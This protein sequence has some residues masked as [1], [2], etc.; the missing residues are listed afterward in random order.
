MKPYDLKLAMRQAL[1]FPKTIVTLDFETYYNSADGYSL[2]KMSTEEY[3]RDP[4][5][6]VHGL[7]VKLG[8]RPSHWLAGEANVRKFLKQIPLHKAWCVAQNSKF[9]GLILTEHFGVRPAMWADTMAMAALLFGNNLPSAS[10][11]ALAARFLPPELAKDK[12][13]LADVDGVEFPTREQMHRLGVYAKGDTDRCR[14]LFDMFCVALLKYRPLELRVVD[15]VTRMFTNPVLELNPTLLEQ[16]LNAERE[17]KAAAIESCLAESSKELNS[18]AKLADLLTGLGVEV[19]TKISPTTGKTTYAFAKTDKEFTDLQY[20]ENPEV[21]KLVAA[22][23]RVKSNIEET[24]AAKY[25]DVALRG[26]W[27]VDL[28]VSGARTTHRFSGGSGGGGNPQNLGRGSPLRQAIIPPKGYHIFA[29][30]SSNIELRIAMVIA[31][32]N[33][34]VQQWFNPTTRDTFDLYKTFAAYLYNCDVSE[35][36][37]DQR[38][39][40]KA[41]MLSLQYGSGAERFMQTAWNWGIELTFAEAARVVAMWRTAFARV[42]HTWKQLGYVVQKLARGTVI[43]SPYAYWAQPTLQTIAD[44]PGFNLPGGMP[45]TY[46]QLKFEHNAAK[47]ER[48]LAYTTYERDYARDADPSSEIP[49]PTHGWGRACR[50]KLY[51]AK[52][53][54]HICQ[55]TA[56]NIVVPQSVLAEQWLRREVDPACEVA[57]SVHDEMVGLIP[58]RVFKGGVSPESVLAEILT[59][60][61]TP[62]DWADGKIPLDAEGGIGKLS[63]GDVKE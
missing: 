16:T 50:N 54:E 48:E 13:A 21:R 61:R 23:L 62:P 45:I 7:A 26:T 53:F 1:Q 20:H 40:G 29:A 31:G 43:E 22:R 39:L 57:L 35:V 18:N 6:R 34:V 58:D 32:E 33:D 19:P 14:A 52:V 25:L 15:W 60:M 59:I 37:S 44:V 10:L 51:G 28:N 55:S 8:S 27:P 4:R 47:G 49:A 5:F 11:A 30:D 24:R 3:V 17:A 42:T 38:K 41:A 46:L 12:A 63:Y 56:R 9:D 2:K 36:T